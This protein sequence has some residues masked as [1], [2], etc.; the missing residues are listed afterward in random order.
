MEKQEMVTALQAELKEF[1]E[2]LPTYATPED[3]TN[4]FESLEAKMKDLDVKED[5]SELRNTI[6]KQGLE[7]VKMNSPEVVVASLEDQIQ[8]EAVNIQKMLKNGHGMV[9]MELKVDV[10]R[11][12]V[13]Q[14]HM[15]MHL[16][17]IED[18]VYKATKLEGLFNSASV[19]PNSNG[20][21]RYVDQA[22]VTRNA[23]WVAEGGTKPESAISWEEFTLP[24]QK[25]A[26]T[27][28]V[29][30]EALEDVGFIA[31]E[32]RNF[33]I[34]NLNL[35][36]DSDLYAG[37]GVSPI[38]FGIYTE[39]DAY[40][41][42]AAGIGGANIY[43]LIVKMAEDITTDSQYQPNVAL[44]NPAEFT[45]MLLSKEAVSFNYITPPFAQVSP[46]GRSMVVNGMTVVSSASVT[47]NTCVVGDFNYATLFNL[48]GIKVDMGWID[49]Q[50]VQNM[51]TIRA[52][53]RVG[54]LIRTVHAN[55]FRKVI[56][57]SAALTT[58]AG[59]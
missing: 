35:K 30:M 46:D 45:D 43:D 18:L 27:I 42:T 17:G 55:A 56:S 16:A 12:N 52:E 39:A 47:A 34:N 59:A 54:L 22:A 20:I 49:K 53:R 9:S 38:I 40:T 50:F 41:A 23:N 13:I 5:L 4:K 1:K 3:L 6:E 26:D 21:I 58:L 51:V 11:A 28:P 19:S 14:N 8:K 25:V 37:S 48:G 7:L 36:L 10:T 44:V 57:V 29:T 24:I 2:G 32:I 15:S 31:S 33:L